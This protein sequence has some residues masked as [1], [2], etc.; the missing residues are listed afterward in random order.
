M[1][2]KL[3]ICFIIFSSNAGTNYA[4]LAN[5]AEEAKKIVVDFINKQYKS[6]PPYTVPYTTDDIGFMDV[7]GLKQIMIDNQ[8][9]LKVL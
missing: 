3:F 6:N 9:T 7:E 1:D 2:K 8:E 5:N 4:V